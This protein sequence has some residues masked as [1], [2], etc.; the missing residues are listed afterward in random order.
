MAD[1]TDANESVVVIDDGVN[2]HIM[3]STSCCFAC[4]TYF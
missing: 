3:E 1:M 2:P 4:F